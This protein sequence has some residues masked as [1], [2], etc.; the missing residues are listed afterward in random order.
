MCRGRIGWTGFRRSQFVSWPPSISLLVVDIEAAGSGAGA[1]TAA[2]ATSRSTG[3]MGHRILEFF[4]AV[5][6]SESLPNGPKKATLQHGQ[7]LVP[8]LARYAVAAGLGSF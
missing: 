8:R 5:P 6:G 7:Q 4:P 3:C 2:S 1:A